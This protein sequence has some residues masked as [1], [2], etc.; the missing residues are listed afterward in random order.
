[1]VFALFGGDRRQASLALQLMADGHEV[2]A[3][4]MEKA[5]LP[6]EIIHTGTTAE[7]VGG[8]DC[9][10]LPLPSS[11][12][13]GFLNAPMAS[14]AHCVGE[15][16]GAA[17]PGQ[18]VC[19]GICDD[20]IRALAELQGVRL[21]DYYAQEAFR[22]V[23][24]VVAAEGAL[25]ILLSETASTLWKSRVLILGWGRLGKALAPRLSALGAD[26]AVS[27]R[28]PGDMAWISAGGFEPLDTRL[29][30]GHLGAFDIVVNTVPAL[31]LTSDLLSELKPPVLLLDLASG[32]GGVD[33]EAAEKLD[34]KALHALSLPGKWAPDTAAAAIKG[35]VYNILAEAL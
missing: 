21:R 33:F 20:Y 12:R 29:L 19:A 27:A 1:M 13:P 16:L 28:T 31:V 18:L 32:P 23:N 14:E 10:I 22:A 15:A 30:K 6:V 3:F 17:S 26:V 11:V 4:A 25:G 34:L 9:V 7:A 24:A 8:A 2:R 35:A 5:V